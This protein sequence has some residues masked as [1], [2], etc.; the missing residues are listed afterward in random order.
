MV[1]GIL[2]TE[3]STHIELAFGTRSPD[4]SYAALVPRD[5]EK[6]GACSFGGQVATKP[7][8]YPLYHC[9]DFFSSIYTS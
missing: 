1:M 3:L 7:F 4:V 8:A 6:A 9:S 2:V 5:Q